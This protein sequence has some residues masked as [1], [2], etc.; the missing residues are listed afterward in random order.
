MHDFLEKRELVSFSLNGDFLP[1]KKDFETTHQ[2]GVEVLTVLP[3]GFAV[4]SIEKYLSRS[5]SVTTRK[6]KYK[7][8]KLHGKFFF[9]EISPEGDVEREIE[10]EFRN[11]KLHG[12][13]SLSRKGRISTFCFVKEE[14]LEWTGHLGTVYGIV[15]HKK[16]SLHVFEKGEEKTFQCLFSDLEAC[17]RETCSLGIGIPSRTYKN[18]KCVTREFLP[19]Y[20]EETAHNFKG[21]EGFRKGRLELLR[22]SLSVRCHRVEM[23]EEEMKEARYPIIISTFRPGE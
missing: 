2:R 8:G 3:D 16:D 14:C 17:Y 22:E 15:S 13:W 9:L 20:R 10:G 18:Y 11:G 19:E 21:K 6:K 23:T 12:R 4:E 7:N 5:G 1:R